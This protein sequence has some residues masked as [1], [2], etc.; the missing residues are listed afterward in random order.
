MALDPADWPGDLDPTSPLETDAI[1]DGDDAIRHLALVMKNAF[2]NVKGAVTATHTE[3]SKL[4]G[5]TGALRYAGGAPIAGEMVLM[6]AVTLS[7]SVA[8]VDFVNGTGGVTFSSAYD[9]YLLVCSGIKHASSSNAKL[10]LD[11]STNAGSSFG[12]ASIS[13]GSITLAG[14]TVAGVNHN[15]LTYFP[16]SGELASASSTLIGVHCEAWLHRPTDDQGRWGIGAQHTGYT[17]GANNASAVT[18]GHALAGATA[19]NAIR[20]MWDS[21]N[22]ANAGSIKLYGRK[23]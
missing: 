9:Q 2:P 3:L 10:R 5:V 1:Q 12:A 15:A 7:G 4:A 6:S 16:L 20:V 19:I 18:T 22:F 8:A 14:T 11:F 13:A 17:G 21:G 23:V